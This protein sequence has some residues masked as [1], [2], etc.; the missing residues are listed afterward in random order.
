[1]CAAIVA[2]AESKPQADVDRE[3][4]R[5]HDMRIGALQERQQW[6]LFV[7]VLLMKGGLSANAARM[8]ADFVRGQQER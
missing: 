6:L 4:A 8:I 7:G 3:S 1:V 2:A 5:R